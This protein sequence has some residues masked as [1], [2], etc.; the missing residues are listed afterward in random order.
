MLFRSVSQGRRQRRAAWA[1]GSL[2]AGPGLSRA[3]RR[4]RGSAQAAGRRRTGGAQIDAD[5]GVDLTRR[6]RRQVS[7]VPGRA[8]E[9]PLAGSGSYSDGAR[10]RTPWIPRRPSRRRAAARRERVCGA[11][12]SC[13]AA[14]RALSTVVDSA[15]PATRCR[16]QAEEHVTANW[17]TWCHVATASALSV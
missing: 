11:F 1:E 2:S 10:G 7:A 12:C 6:A 4:R 8:R 13:Q 3:A 14:A 17:M 15:G 5:D 16:P 9:Q